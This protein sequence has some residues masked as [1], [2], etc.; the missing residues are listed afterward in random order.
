MFTRL[1]LLCFT[2]TVILLLMVY[3]KF[4][5]PLLERSRLIK[6]GVFFLDCPM[7][8]E[9]SF[10]INAVRESPYEPSFNLIAEYLGKQRKDGQLPPVTGVCLPARVL[11]SI[12][13][14]D[15]LEDIYVRYN[16]YN[17]KLN[18]QRSEA[19]LFDKT[20]FFM[21]TFHKEYA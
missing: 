15:F 6:Q 21:D 5:R 13:S 12:N 18:E 14:I 11:I 8:S 7:V 2:I 10:F 16:Q 1:Q 20:V 19:F 3:K 4:C 17:G 9:I